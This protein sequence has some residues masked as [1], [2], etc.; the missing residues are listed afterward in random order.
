MCGLKCKEADQAL[1]ELRQGIVAQWVGAGRQSG[2][3][4]EEKSCRQCKVVSPTAH[5]RSPFCWLV[6]W[7]GVFS[8]K[9]WHS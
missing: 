6:R 9:A 4:C 5:F 7:S 1:S 8:R 3:K 2:R